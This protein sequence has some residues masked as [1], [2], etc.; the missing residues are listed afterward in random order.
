MKRA[1]GTALATLLII[2]TGYS[3]LTSADVAA[4][5]TVEIK[6]F[7]FAPQ[8]VTVTR[9]TTVTWIN[10]DQTAHSVVAN[11]GGFS[12]KGMDTDDKFTFTFTTPGDYAYIC[13]LHPHMT[14]VVHVR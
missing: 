9:G 2:A 14:G 6:A 11:Q 12:S 3:R 8:E 13:S 4:P 1:I 5:P 7:V 10:R